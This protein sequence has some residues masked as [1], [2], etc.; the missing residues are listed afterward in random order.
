MPLFDEDFLKK[1]EYLYV[2]SKKIFVGKLR[3]ERKTKKTA[4]GIEFADHRNYA[5]G[6]EIRALD[7]RVYAR[8]EKLLIRLFEE[9]EDLNIYFL[10]DCSASMNFNHEKKLNYAK[11]MAAALGYI[12]LCNQDRVAF[13]AFDQKIAAHLPLSSGRGQIF[14]IFRFLENLN[15]QGMTDFKDAFKAF[16][17]QTKRRGLAVVISDFENPDGFQNALNFLHYQQFETYAVHIIDDAEYQIDTFGDVSLI[18]AETGEQLDLTLSPKLITQYKKALEN[19]CLKLEAFCVQ[20]HMLYFRTPVSE[21]FDEIVL[22]VFRAG[23]F[24]K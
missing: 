18:D 8:T 13:F 1:I 11:K 7:W 6:D 24:L 23:G 9:K 20:R 3:A 21:P 5:P 4:S 22:K 19:L 17:G 16:A 15:A 12:G 2:M 10:I 14:K